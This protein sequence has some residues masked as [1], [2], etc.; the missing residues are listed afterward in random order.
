MLSDPPTHCQVENE[1]ID[2]DY[3]SC[4]NSNYWRFALTFS[5]PGSIDGHVDYVA[6]ARAFLPTNGGGKKICFQ[7]GN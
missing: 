6:G 7:N 2:D 1:E 5:I 3:R 4:L